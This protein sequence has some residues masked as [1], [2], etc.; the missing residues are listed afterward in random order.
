[1][2]SRILAGLLLM[3]FATTAAADVNGPGWDVE[4]TRFRLEPDLIRNAGPERGYARSP[5]FAWHLVGHAPIGVNEEDEKWATGG[6]LRLEV[7][8]P[9]FTF[10]SVGG[11]FEGSWRGFYSEW[12]YEYV[13]FGVLDGGIHARLRLSI[14]AMMFFIGGQLGVTHTEGY[15]RLTTWHGGGHAGMRAGGRVGVVLQIGINVRDWSGGGIRQ[16]DE[17]FDK[18]IP[19]FFGSVGMSVVLGEYR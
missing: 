10:L 13:H 18:P 2:R 8:V 19:E 9:I 4:P 12:E 14:G 6:G 11:Y 3:S 17:T 15:A 16:T 5:T 7:D 1:M